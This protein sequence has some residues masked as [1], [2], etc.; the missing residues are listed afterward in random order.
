MISDGRLPL[1]EDNVDNPDQG[2]NF[3]LSNSPNSLRN[4]IKQYKR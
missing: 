2:R 3:S 1:W 4:S